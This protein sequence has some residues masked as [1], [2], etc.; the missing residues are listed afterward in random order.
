M[1]KTLLVAG[2]LAL[3]AV[4]LFACRGSGAEPVPTGKTS[5]LEF[6]LVAIDGTPHSLA[7]YRGKVVLLVNTASRCGFT[8]QYAGLEKLSLAHQAEGLVIIGIPS[9]D[10]L[11]QEPG[12]DAEIQS[13]CQ[14][15]YGVTFPLMSKVVVKGAG[16]APLYTYLTHESPFPG[17]ISWNFNKFL[18]GRDGKVSAR[19]GSKT[20]PEDPELVAAVQTALAAKPD[21]AGTQ[22]TKK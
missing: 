15:N 13:F 20:A 5:P 2:A 16:Q 18:I 1:Y 17:A 3:G 7:Q 9:N 12:S 19:F 21:S 8:K 14:K 11:G 22:E 10:F 4:I 6:D